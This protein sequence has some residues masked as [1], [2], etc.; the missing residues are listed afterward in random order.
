M[1]RNTPQNRFVAE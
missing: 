1:K